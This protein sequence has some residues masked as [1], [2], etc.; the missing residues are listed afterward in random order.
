M[1]NKE[2]FVICQEFCIT[3]GLS[4]ETIEAI[5]NDIKRTYDLKISLSP[6]IN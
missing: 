6:K 1:I 3:D 2:N 4:K 5:K